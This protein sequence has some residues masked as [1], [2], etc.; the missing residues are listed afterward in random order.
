MRGESGSQEEMQWKKKA[1]PEFINIFFT[2]ND[3]SH[4]QNKVEEKVC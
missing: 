1:G 4:G 2:I 3:A